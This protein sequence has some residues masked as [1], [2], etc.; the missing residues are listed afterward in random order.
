MLKLANF[1]DDI[2]FITSG[3]QN[4]IQDIGCGGKV[5]FDR[6][7]VSALSRPINP[8]RLRSHPVVLTPLSVVRKSLHTTNQ[9]Q[10][11]TGST[12]ITK[13]KI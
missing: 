10:E 9:T 6:V 1:S 5:D 11:A 13:C 3:S 7:G 12:A 4:R 2:F 8:Q